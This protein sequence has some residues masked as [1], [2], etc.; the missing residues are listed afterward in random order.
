MRQLVCNRLLPGG[1]LGCVRFIFLLEVGC[2][3]KHFSSAV[4]SGGLRLIPS[5][6][7]VLR[8]LDREYFVLIFLSPR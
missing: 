4:A 1:S 8:K 3:Q 5:A 6:F 2:M 7:L